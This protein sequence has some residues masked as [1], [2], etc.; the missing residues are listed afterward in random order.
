MPPRAAI[1]GEASGRSRLRRS[2]PAQATFDRTSGEEGV[3]A[4][5]G[6]MATSYRSHV[7]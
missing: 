7:V 5:I 4:G 1:A 2:G 3:A 6:Q